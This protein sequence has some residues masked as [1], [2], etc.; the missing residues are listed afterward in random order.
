MG[1]MMNHIHLKTTDVAATRKFYEDNYGATFKAEMNG[2]VQMDLHGLQVNITTI[3]T[4]QN[5]EQH[6]GIEHIALTTDDYAGT[7]AKLRGN[8][9]QVLEELISNG[10]HVAFLQSPDGAQMEI[11][12]RK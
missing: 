1:L 6:Y 3:M 10:R 12:E 2:G 7:M 8:G 4:T 5:H 11:I 9:V